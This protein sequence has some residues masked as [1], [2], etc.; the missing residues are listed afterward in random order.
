MASPTSTAGFCS[1][2]G[3]EP[4]DDYNSILATTRLA[5]IEFPSHWD[6]TTLVSASTP[7]A[8]QLELT[9][10]LQFL[11]WTASGSFPFAGIRYLRTL[12]ESMDLPELNLLYALELLHLPGVTTTLTEL[13]A[14]L[15]SVHD[16]QVDAH[17]LLFLAMG[18]W[19]SDVA[20]VKL[21]VLKYPSARDTW[22]TAD[23]M[24]ALSPASPAPTWSPTD[25][26]QL[27][28]ALVDAEHV[29]SPAMESLLGMIGIAKVKRAAI[30]LFQSARA[31]K[32]M[33]LAMQKKNPL[34]LNFCFV[35][36]AGTGKT[37]VAR[38]FATLLYESGHRPKD[39]FVEVSAQLLLDQTID[40]FRKR[41]ASAKDGVLFIDEAFDLDPD[42]DVKGRAI[43]S[44][45][46]TLAEKYRNNL[47]IILAGYE[48]EMETKL[49]GFNSGLKSRFQLIPFDAMNEAE[50]HAVWDLQL[51]ARGW[52]APPELATIV[53]KRLAMRAHSKDFGNA[54]SVRKEVE[55]ATMSAM[56]RPTFDGAKL[57]LRVD[58]VI[59]DH[60]LHNPTLERVLGELEGKIGWTSIK[61]S[62]HDL[63]QH[64]EKN[65]KRQL[66]G[67]APLPLMLNRLFLGN[68]GTGKTSCAAL[69]GRI[70]KEL[71]LLSSGDVVLKTAS[72][73][74]GHYS[75]ETQ[76]KTQACLEMARGKVL[77]IDEAYNLDNSRYGKQA[78]DVLVEKIQNTGYD[79]M[80]VLLLGYEDKM[81][82]MLRDQNPGLARRFP[83]DAA[84]VFDDYSPVELLQ[85]LQYACT[86]N[87]I[88]CSADAMEAALVEL[89]RQKRLAHFGNAGAVNAL[90]QQAMVK[91]TRRDGPIVLLAADFVRDDVASPDMDAD[92]LQ[93]L[94]GLY[95][96]DDIKS[97]LRSL[98]NAMQVAD[99]EGSPRPELGHFVFR[100]SPG[101]GKTT[102]ARAVATILYQLDL[103]AV[104]HVEETSGLGLTGEYLGQTKKRVAEKLD[105]ANGGVLFIDE[106][107]ALGDKWYGQEAMT[108]LVA[109]MTDPA[110]SGLVIVI[111]GYPAD[112]DRM[113]DRNVG[114]KSRFTQFFD[115]PDWA[116]A[117]CMAFLR[118]TI[119]RDNYIASEDVLE[120]IE[121]HLDAVRRLPGWGNGRD[122]K[123]LWNAVLTAR[124]DRIVGRPADVEKTIEVDDVDTAFT[125]MIAARTPVSLS[126]AR[127]EIAPVQ[128]PG[129]M[130]P[131][132]AMRPTETT[133]K[134]DAPEP[135]KTDDGDAFRQNDDIQRDA[136]V[137]DADWAELEAAKM[138]HAAYLAGRQQEL[139]A[140]ALRLELAKAAAV[141]ERIRRLCPC[142]A[143][144]AWF[145]VAGGWRCA[146]G[147]HYVTDAQLTAQ[148]TC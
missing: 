78:L 45:L 92:P 147:G 41:A 22:L 89:E 114:L 79:D 24:R 11:P 133:R 103:L 135:A 56:A 67:Q 96:M 25:P 88:G 17:P 120:C 98:R 108:T 72:D 139:D 93:L 33:S 106:A 29:R 23:E 134:Q 9:K 8:V 132:P 34:S 48:D 121:G 127:A 51:Q 42:R 81:L 131:P 146:G 140:E 31:R 2:T 20:Y 118:A 107:Y 69:Y 85:L 54:R 61:K 143:G 12:Q 148:F 32:K 105:A 46:I 36:G 50:L 84:F 97:R 63:V 130:P 99:A 66:S 94:D 68:P 49:F 75:G 129:S 3:D 126:D 117:D 82:A 10:K 7:R 86:R 43:V 113:L 145:K 28:R 44:E 64:C 65:Y 77:V 52:T 102:V 30:Q 128:T 142:P 91:A 15:S 53:S 123:Q 60:P 73:L 21:F 115:F 13:E 136:G 14:Y 90:V 38:L 141:Q 144:F 119:A 111:A 37:T 55:A 27:W 74:I 137:S 57:V 101:T 59:G 1:N 6:G 16:K 76:T 109:A 70:L 138:V 95:R 100:G 35:G 5:G 110:Y 87:E 40:V 47:T 112:M 4:L 62:V 58:D 80:A 39:V 83:R 104:D 71:H 18:R 116:T 122:V 19:T 124:A 26:S 125:A